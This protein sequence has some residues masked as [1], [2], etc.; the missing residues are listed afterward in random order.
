MKT[1][2]YSLV[3]GLFSNLALQRNMTLKLSILLITFIFRCSLEL[4]LFV[5]L[6][7][8]PATLPLLTSPLLCYSGRLRLLYP[9]Y[10]VDLSVPHTLPPATLLFPYYDR[11]GP[12][13]PPPP[14]PPR[15]LPP[16]PRSRRVSG[17]GG[18]E[19]GGV[20]SG[21]GGTGAGGA[22]TYPTRQLST[23]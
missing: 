20:W 2:L 1:N 4:V 18:A 5:L 10:E 19:G 21:G 7:G 22:Y 12:T 15:V 13:P 16:L 8:A 3:V 11:L 6:W 17:G 9:Y 14:P 23:A